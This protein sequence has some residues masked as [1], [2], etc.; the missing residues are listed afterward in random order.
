MCA[1]G[2]AVTPIDSAVGILGTAGPLLYFGVG[3]AA[4]CPAELERSRSRR[5]FR[6]F[7][8]GFVCIFRRSGPTP[9]PCPRSC[10]R[11]SLNQGPFA[12]PALPGFL[13]TTG[14]SATHTARPDPH[15]LPVPLHARG[16]L[17][18]PALRAIPLPCMPTPIPRRDL[19]ARSLVSPEDSG[20]PSVNERSAPALAFSRP[21]QRSLTFRPAWSPSRPRRPSAP[22]A[23]VASLPPPPLR[24]LPAGATSCRV[25][26]APTG[27]RRLFAAHA[28]PLLTQRRPA[29][30]PQ[31][32]NH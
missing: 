1:G 23:S 30:E 31:K 8:V 24:L 7:P 29:R 2:K 22:E 6:R 28:Y 12:P 3:E 19:Q 10:E 5:F 9:I 25:G 18:L 15:G 16:P 14:L 26:F 20:L 17:G 4:V 11:C 32:L 21:A 13:A 27:N